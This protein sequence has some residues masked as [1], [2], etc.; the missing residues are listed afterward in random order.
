[1]RP[2]WTLAL[3]LTLAAAARV[4]A[5]DAPEGPP[6]LR[7]SLERETAVLRAELDLAR[8]EGFYLRLDVRRR[9]LSLMLEGVSLQDHAL[10]AL[11]TASPRVLF[12]RR[13]PPP[14]WERQSWAGG[15]LDP[16]RER[17]RTEVM[18]PTP[19]PREDEAAAEPSPPPIPPTAEE[20]YSVPA[21]YRVVFAA[22]PTVEVTADDGGRN[23]GLL[24]RAVDAAALR[25][26]DILSAF[27]ASG[28]VR[29]RI[30]LRMSAEDAAA[31]YRS[32]PPDVGLVVVGLAPR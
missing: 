27:R 16:A 9:Q 7:T 26:D 28:P 29:V 23:R 8:G 32:L 20:A 17:D 3:I 24:Q 2:P 12:W 21:R 5:L 10:E 4:V 31:L 19:S 1:M 11:E 6:D 25:A 15:R 14:D 13:P 22:G 30:R 18:A